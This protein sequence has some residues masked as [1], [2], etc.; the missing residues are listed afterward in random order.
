MICC[1]Q[2]KTMM[3]FITKKLFHNTKRGYA[4]KKKKKQQQALKSFI[5]TNFCF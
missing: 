3:P 5:K 2:S 1:S 4:D